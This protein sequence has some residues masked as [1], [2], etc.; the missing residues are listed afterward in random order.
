L[1]EIHSE[2]SVSLLFFD[3]N[4]DILIAP[5]LSSGMNTTPKFFVESRGAENNRLNKLLQI[6]TYLFVIGDLELEWFK[7]MKFQ[8]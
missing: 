2:L 4:R 6:V 7:N 5:E 8:Q 1:T 3:R